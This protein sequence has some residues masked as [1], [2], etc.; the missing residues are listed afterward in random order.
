MLGIVLGARDTAVNSKNKNPCHDGGSSFWWEQ[1]V[2]NRSNIFKRYE[3]LVNP[4]HVL[5]QYG[6]IPQLYA[7][8]IHLSTLV[9]DSFI[10]ECEMTCKGIFVFL[11]IF[12][13]VAL[14]GQLCFISHYQGLYQLPRDKISCLTSKVGYSRW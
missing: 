14:L 10:F 9:E 6:S 12:K 5:L 3:F 2:I 13:I 11:V 4:L 8:T 1:A 7:V